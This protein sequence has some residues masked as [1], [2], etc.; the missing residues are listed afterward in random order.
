MT[1]ENTVILFFHSREDTTSKGCS[2]SD[3]C[4]FSSSRRIWV[5]TKI[6]GKN[7]WLGQNKI[8]NR[9][10]T[11]ISMSI[12]RTPNM[13]SNLTWTM[14]RL[15]S[16]CARKRTNK[17]NPNK[18]LCQE[19]KLGINCGKIR[20]PLTAPRLLPKRITYHRVDCMVA[21]ELLCSDKKNIKWI[22]NDKVVHKL[23]ASEHVVHFIVLCLCLG[24]ILGPMLGFCWRQHRRLQWLHRLGVI[25]VLSS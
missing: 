22:W 25:I 24:P 2:Q 5:N 18:M 20:I 6:S 14:R 11:K 7:S 16:L 1:R 9:S 15:K 13:K 3:S 12:S 17:I 21:K 10:Q 8:T 19:V 23:R 4:Y